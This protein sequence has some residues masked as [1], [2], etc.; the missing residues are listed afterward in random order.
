MVTYRAFQVIPT[1]HP[2][3]L[4]MSDDWLDGV[5]TLQWTSQ[6]L[7]FDAALLTRDVDRCR[8]LIMAPVTTIDERRVNCTTR[9]SAHLYQCIH[10]GV[11]VKRVP[12]QSHAA[13][14]EVAPVSRRYTSLHTKLIAFMG[15]AFTD[16]FHF[17]C[18]Q[19]V[20]LVAVR[21]LLLQHTL[22][23]RQFIGKD[24]LL[25]RTICDFP[26]NVAH[27]TAQVGPQLSDLSTHAPEVECIG[28]G[29][30]HKRYEFGVKAST[31]SR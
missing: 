4:E 15:F 24:P 11:T 17:R 9:Q 23:H 28:K 16:A 18:M 7:C 29:K 20:Q 27:H 30:A 12:G 31:P 6:S 26:L 5:P 22:R 25:G 13:H 3:G 8:F 1:K 19:A 14:D 2:V 10:Q 21:L